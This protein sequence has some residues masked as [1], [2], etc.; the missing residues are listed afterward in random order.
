MYIWRKYTYMHKTNVQNLIDFKNYLD[1]GYNQIK[2]AELAGIPVYLASYYCKKNKWKAVGK[3]RKYKVNDNYFD[4][5][6]TEDK[7]YLLGFFIADGYLRVENGRSY[8]IAINNSID[9]ES[10]INLFK[11]KICPDNFISKINKQNGVKYFRKPQLEIRWTSEYMYNILVNKYG[12]INKKTYNLD[13]KFP[14]ELVPEHLI[15]HFIRGFFDGDGNITYIQKSDKT[16]KQFNF[17]FIFTSKDFCNQIAEIFESKFKMYR[18]ITP[19][20]S[21]NMTSYQLR[22]NFN[23]KRREVLEIVYKWLYE[24]SEYYLERKKIKFENYLNTV[25]TRNLKNRE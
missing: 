1:Q 6:D 20:K 22:F 21:K 16:I 3:Q 15:R 9:D 7:A 18:K 10:I 17:S 12:I 13:F 23:L 2:S 25:L 4:V 24:N 19:Q 11:N 8:R 5:I 14:F